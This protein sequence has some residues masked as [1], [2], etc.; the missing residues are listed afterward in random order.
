M[1]PIWVSG[2]YNVPWVCF[3][4]R[5]GVILR[6]SQWE[7]APLLEKTPLGA[8]DGNDYESVWSEQHTQSQQTQ[9]LVFLCRCSQVYCSREVSLISSIILHGAVLEALVFLGAPVWKEVVYSCGNMEMVWGGKTSEWI[10]GR[11]KDAVTLHILTLTIWFVLKKR[12]KW[13]LFLSLKEWCGR[14]DMK[15]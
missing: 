10:G 7:G 14:T 11:L 5:V 2:M 9:K 6:R 13:Q 15:C 4:M 8:I 12:G 3:H 1:C